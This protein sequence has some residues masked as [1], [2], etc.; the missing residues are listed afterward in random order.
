MGKSFH[1]LCK[2]KQLSFCSFLLDNCGAYMIY[3]NGFDDLLNFTLSQLMVCGWTA[4]KSSEHKHN[5]ICFFGFCHF[6]K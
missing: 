3:L 5:F 2:K 1:L 4:M 6:K